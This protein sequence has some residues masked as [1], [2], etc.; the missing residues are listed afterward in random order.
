[1]PVS[2][3]GQE[4]VEGNKKMIT[5]IKLH[6]PWDL[7]CFY[8]EDLSMRAALQ[9]R[10]DLLGSPVN[11]MLEASGRCCLHS[12]ELWTHTLNMQ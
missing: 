11:G 12:V 3:L 10:D 2:F 5:Y 9:V 1:M 8:A 6:A 7:L 4:H